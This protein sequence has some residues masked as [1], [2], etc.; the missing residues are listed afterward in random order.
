MF[1]GFAE[2]LRLRIA[3]V[4]VRET[5]EVLDE[6]EP[7]VVTERFVDDEAFVKRGQSVLEDTLP[8]DAGALRHFHQRV[9]RRQHRVGVETARVELLV[10]RGG[11]LRS[12]GCVAPVVQRPIEH[13]GFA[14]L[15]L[16]LPPGL[17]EISH[18]CDALS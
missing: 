17:A 1:L 14:V 4:E 16:S 8:F 10:Q 9:A 3:A 15:R 6:R 7:V 11:R 13:H 5:G 12:A 18:S 2:I